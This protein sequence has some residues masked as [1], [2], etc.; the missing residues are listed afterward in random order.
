MNESLRKK[1][2]SSGKLREALEII[3]LE[4]THEQLIS[5]DGCAI[6]HTHGVPLIGNCDP[7]KHGQP[8]KKS[9]EGMNKT[10]PLCYSTELLT[11]WK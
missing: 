11:S 9:R 7:C 10:H 3:N 1:S 5:P 8:A 6:K 4:T 2:F